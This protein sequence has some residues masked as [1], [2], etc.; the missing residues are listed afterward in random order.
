MVLSVVKR[1][2]RILGS[3][4]VFN[5][6]RAFKYTVVDNLLLSVA[7]KKDLIADLQFRPN[8]PPKHSH[9]A[10]F[11]NPLSFCHTSICNKGV[12]FLVY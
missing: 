12:S 11:H 1:I 4:A 6:V 2:L 9:V 10:F 7:L 8:L 5:K 3:V